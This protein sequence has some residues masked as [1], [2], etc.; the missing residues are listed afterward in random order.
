MHRKIH[1]APAASFLGLSLSL[2]LTACYASAGTDSPLKQ[3][4]AAAQQAYTKGDYVVAESEYLKAINEAAKADA[5]TRI[6][7]MVNLGAT[8][9]EQ[10]KFPE[11]EES[12]K[13][14]LKLA[15]AAHLTTDHSAVRAMQ[16]YAAL[17]RKMK[18]GSEADAMDAKILSLTD[19]TQTAGTNK[20]GESAGQSDPHRPSAEMGTI[21]ASP[22]AQAA[23]SEYRS[24]SIEE[25]K[26][27][28]NKNPSEAPAWFWLG[29]QYS[30]G[31]DFSNAVKAF[32][33]ALQMMKPADIKDSELHSNLAVCLYKN[34]SYQEAVTE[35]RLA[36]KDNPTNPTLYDRLAMMCT[37]AGD[38]QASIEANQ[39]FLDKFPD[40]PSRARIQSR[41][42]Y[43]KS[44][45]A[46]ISAKQASEVSKMTWSMASMP[47][48]VY[49]SDRY[50]DFQ[51][52]PATNKTEEIL[53]NSVNDI[54]RRAMDSWTQASGSK[55]SFV[56]I[57]DPDKCNIEVSFTDD[58]AG[59]E[60]Q[61]AQGITNFPTQRGETKARI[62]LLTLSAQTGKP[63]TRAAFLE[64]A[65]HEFGHAL[66]L[67][68]HSSS[69]NDIMYFSVHPLPMTAP[70][71][72][73]AERLQA[74][75][76]NRGM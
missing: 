32:Q 68:V 40:D 44:E 3:H 75:Y 43:E 35:Q 62:K 72:H 42:D 57:D 8:Y 15:D 34:G 36:I 50:N 52:K 54:L 58:K 27:I 49:I 12:F 23:G 38:M 5:R 47:L 70:S 61:F 7:L 10:R 21:S 29:I 11:A 25:L 37:A 55:C 69:A 66:G 67:L 53:E 46:K 76:I 64:S 51:F 41:M 1:L 73:D 65:I 19:K 33:T 24:K 26:A 28:V 9:R 17:L 45:V 30:T 13:K 48:K 59:L 39:Q 20:D 56:V 6:I 2:A 63:V 31:E 22:K 60:E 74:I 4:N 71:L 16:Q 18:R 14:A